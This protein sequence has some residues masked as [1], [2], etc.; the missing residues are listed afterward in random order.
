MMLRV[1]IALTALLAGG[2]TW[3]SEA[4]RARARQ[5]YE[6]RDFT[7]AAAALEAHLRDKPD[8]RDARVLLG[9]CRYQ[10]GRHHE[11]E[12]IFREAI[13]GNARDAQAHFY[14]ALTEHLQGKLLEAEA[15]AR[16][17]MR[18]GWSAARSLRL[19][20]KTREDRNRLDDA[21]AAYL[22]AI[23]EDPSSGDAWLGAGEVLLKLRRVP[24][25][26]G[27]LKQARVLSPE[28]AETAFHLGRALILAGQQAASEQHLADAARLGHPGA[29]RLLRR[30]RSTGAP[31]ASAI[32]LAE[33]MP[34]RFND[35]AAEAGLRFVLE[36][37]ATP[38]KRLIETMAGGVA[39]FDYNGDGLM[40]LFLTNG[41]DTPSMKKVGIRY[42]NRLFRNDGNLRFTDVTATAGVEGAGF[43]IGA[44]AADF[45]N[46][47][48]PDFFVAGFPHNLLYRNLG[49]GRFADVTRQAGIRSGEWSV[50]GGWFDYDNDGRLDLFVVNYLDW[51]PKDDRFCGDSA[52][53]IRTYCN[54]S[55]YRGT[56]NRLYRNK[57]NGVFED[58]SARS[59]IAAHTGKGMSLAFADYDEDGFMDVF[60]TNDRVPN[61]LFRN[62]GDGTFE[63]QALAAGP[64][65]NDHGLAISAM[66]VDFR[67]YNNDG[68]PDLIFTA[69]TGET[70]PLFRNQRGGAFFDRT[71]ADGAG[72]LS[73]GRS[74][75]N[76]NL[77]DFNNDGWKDVFTANSHVTDNVEQFSAVEKYMQ[78]N[79]LWLNLGDGTFVDGS[80]GAGSGFAVARA[81]RGGAVADFDNDGRLDVVVSSLAGP[82]EL[83][84]NI[85]PAAG[86]WLRV[87]LEG[88]RSNRD[89]IGARVRVGR[90]LQTVTVNAGYASSTRGGAHFGLSSNGGPVSIEILWPSGVRQTV[91]AA[92]D[93]I[94]SVREPED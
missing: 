69:L 86:H 43:S 63:E 36:N 33:P 85:S 70:F 55:F 35:V 5:L 49:D 93:T 62:R 24:D 26:V 15:D 64:A 44:A 34:V 79:S 22:E 53:R 83:W 4:D 10:L 57:G 40:D 78:P 31:A 84:H 38:E 3:S 72:V 67:D 46:D 41:A 61:F 89:G 80:A 21:L 90:Q 11:A 81:H 6:R 30:I 73:A 1:G 12:Q 8:D 71:Y 20:G 59:G 58:V 48:H 13:R 18:L 60:V 32:D 76:V 19:I 54:P 14:L 45:D 2:V 66:G 56:A 9:L 91:N 51:S 28:D 87:E 42:A 52:T 77:A 50:A 82:V 68:L 94:V 39:A 47:G 74:G 7:A 17:A 75:W 23:R 16:Q 27:R 65:L 88:R 29:E 37:H 92:A 25:A